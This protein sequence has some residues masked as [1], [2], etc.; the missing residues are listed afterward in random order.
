MALFALYLA[1]LLSLQAQPAELGRIAF[2]TSGPPEAQKHFERGVL[3]LH[4]FEYRDARMAFLSAQRAAPDF[5][6]GYWGEA[7]T[8]NEPLWFAQDLESAR[9]ALKRLPAAAPTERERAYLAAV[10]ILYGDGK[11]EDRDFEYATAMRRLHEKYPEDPEAAAFYALSLIGTCHRGRDFRTYMKAAAIVESVL[12][13]N[14][15]HPGALHYA[16]HA[17]DDPIH[18][19]LGLRA[20]RVY[21][22]VAPAAAH[23]QHMPSHIFFAMGMWDEA[24]KSNEAAWRTSQTKQPI[25]SGGYHALWWLQ[26]AYLQQ[27]RFADARRALEMME[28]MA[29]AQPSPL[30]RFHL[31]Q[32]SA[33]YAIETGEPHKSGV[34]TSGLDLPARAAS[35][36][37]AGRDALNRGRREDAENSLAALRNLKP[38]GLSRDS[39][40]GHIYAGDVQ[41]AAIMENQLVALVLM[42]DGKSKEAIELM[43]QAVAAEDKMPY[44]FGPPMPPKPAHEQLGEILL[45]LGRPDLARVQFELALLRAPKRA[46]SL[47]GLA[48]ANDQSGNKVEAQ[49][50]YSE[51]RRLWSRADPE[52]L[53]A[54]DE[55][56][57]RL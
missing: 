52:I 36:F 22:K 28:K 31:V 41:A 4:S 54:L 44:E 7:M 27:G 9:A 8:Y 26:Y 11:K 29:T 57:G 46:L 37:A 43:K 23:A 20:A 50:A 47:L 48:R 10:E 35:L 45:S 34:D 17:Y 14:P 13:K 40:H 5:A 19:P 15:D 55:S 2:P 56:I 39:H 38:S 42:A 6:M 3:L 49:E 53:K 24:A 16:I 21:A 51:L 25:E 33:M 32:M 12:E 1:S 30:L 18:A